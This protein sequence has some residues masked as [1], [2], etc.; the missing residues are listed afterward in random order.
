MPKVYGN[1]C[2]FFGQHINIASPLI[3]HTATPNWYIYSKGLVV[4]YLL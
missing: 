1:E 2:T 4:A 3:D